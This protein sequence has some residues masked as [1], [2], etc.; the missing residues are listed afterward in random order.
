MARISKMSASAFVLA[1]ACCRQARAFV[2]AGTA[3]AAPGLRTSAAS[4]MHRSLHPR[5]EQ[6]ALGSSRRSA[7]GVSMLK[8]DGGSSSGS[9]VG[10]SSD[11][12]TSGNNSGASTRLEFGVGMGA[13]AA[14]AFVLGGT[15]AGGPK[16]ALADDDTGA[17]GAAQEAT[18][19]AAAPEAASAAAA[20]AAAE[21]APPLRDLGIEVPYTGKSVPLSKFL[22][23]RATL[24]V[25]PKID[26]PESLHQVCLR[27]GFP[28]LAPCFCCFCSQ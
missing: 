9:E 15:T 20:P 12:A 24:V 1:L 6:T 5:T 17:P 19:E 27:D 21:A 16:R 28:C 14:A 11:D 3:A 23:S 18:T 10:R 26:D 4:N 25:N 8:R 22:G 7:R 13:A 2:P